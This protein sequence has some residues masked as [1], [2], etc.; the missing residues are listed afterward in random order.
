MHDEIFRGTSAEGS[1]IPSYTVPM[2]L[3]KGFPG[4]HKT[5]IDINI[6]GI[7]E[8]AVHDI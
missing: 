1:T 5:K 8:S 2:V 6:E 4:H 7:L 3:V